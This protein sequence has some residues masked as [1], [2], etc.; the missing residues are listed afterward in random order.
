MAT[1]KTKVA[2]K[3]ESVKKV[4]KVAEVK[5]V[6]TPRT[7]DTRSLSF[8]TKDGKIDTEALKTAF[9]GILKDAERSNQENLA[10]ARR[11]RINTTNM[12]NVFLS[13]RKIT[14]KMGS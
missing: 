7:L 9:D 11:F 14:P 2:P 10:A 5:E 13:L 6:K 12:S 1:T 4:T 8:S 3:K